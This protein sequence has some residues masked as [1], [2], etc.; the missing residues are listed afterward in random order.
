[1]TVQLNWQACKDSKMYPDAWIQTFTGKAFWPLEPDPELIC[2]ED[3]AWALAHQSRYSGHCD[4]FY[5]VAEHSLWVSGQCSPEHKL[6]GLLHDA[7]EAYLS[8]VVRPKST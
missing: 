7:S 6:W 5:S 3:I 2:I 1:M 4:R 8:D